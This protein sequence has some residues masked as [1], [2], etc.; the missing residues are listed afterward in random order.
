M[1]VEANDSPRAEEISQDNNHWL[2]Q[3][4]RGFRRKTNRENTESNSL[5]TNPTSGTP[6]SP[7]IL[8]SGSNGSSRNGYSNVRG[9]AGTVPDKSINDRLLDIAYE[10]QNKV[11]YQEQN[12]E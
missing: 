10:G 12:S 11:L 5:Q 3:R 6:K 2:T 8:A 7:P 1:P 4:S 9:S